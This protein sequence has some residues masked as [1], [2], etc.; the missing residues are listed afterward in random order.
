MTFPE[1]T[2]PWVGQDCGLPLYELVYTPLTGL[3]LDTASKTFTFSTTDPAEVGSHEAYLEV[4]L[5]DHPQF[6]PVIYLLQPVQIVITAACWNTVMLFTPV[7]LIH[8]VRTPALSYQ[9]PAVS[10]DISLEDD[11]LNGTGYCGAR[12]YEDVSLTSIDHAVPDTSVSNFDG[13]DTYLLEGTL[14]D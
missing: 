5:T 7:S 12:S 6:N 2:Y 9:L 8:K 1:F 4:G 3:I 10:D 13:T 11:P 14:N